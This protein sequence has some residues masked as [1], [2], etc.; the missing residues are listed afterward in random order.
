VSKNTG[1]SLFIK[2]DVNGWVVPIRAPEVMRDILN[3]LDQN[4]AKLV[5]IIKS[6][7][8]LSP[9]GSWEDTAAMTIED[10]TNRCA[11]KSSMHAMS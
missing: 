10:I 8:T 7:N 4:R 6:M 5:G 11:I 9:P 3:D 2:D 1:S